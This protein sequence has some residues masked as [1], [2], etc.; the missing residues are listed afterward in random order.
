MFFN[1]ILNKN[2][3]SEKNPINR[4]YLNTIT[5]KWK[6]VDKAADDLAQRT[7]GM[8]EFVEALN[9]FSLELQNPKYRFDRSTK[10]GFKSNHEIF[11]VAYLDDLLTLLLNR[12]PMLQDGGIRWGYQRFCMNLRFYQ[13]NLFSDK[14]PDMQFPESPKFLMLSQ[15]LDLQFRLKGRRNFNKYQI[16]TPIL[17]FH[18]FRNFMEEHFIR[19]DYYSR[20]AKVSYD[21]CKSIVIAETI[22]ENFYPE[23][24]DSNIDNIFLLRGQSRNGQTKSFSLEIVKLLDEKIEEYLAEGDQDKKQIIKSGVIE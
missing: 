17:L 11:S 12:H 24:E 6:K 21:R 2:L 7:G 22:D 4:M 23:L 16:T 9:D 14:N 15:Q 5:I 13:K 8:R 3:K 1:D 10:S 19:V 18:T 20:L